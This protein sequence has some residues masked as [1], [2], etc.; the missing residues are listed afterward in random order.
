MGITNLQGA[1]IDYL[2]TAVD[3]LGSNITATQNQL[4]TNIDTNNTD[5]TNAL[6][7][8]KTD[9]TNLINSNKSTQDAK[10]TE[11]DSYLSTLDSKTATNASNITALQTSDNDKFKTAT[12]SNATITDRIVTGKQIGRAHV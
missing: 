12:V 3:N 10:N 1:N 8:V 2:K 9:L 11:Y 4:Q 5:Q 7:T 6:N